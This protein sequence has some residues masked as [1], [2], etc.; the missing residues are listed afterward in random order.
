MSLSDP[1]ADM[2][3]R[4]SNAHGAGLDVVEMPFS[5]LKGEI[6]RLLKREGYVTDFVVEGDVKKTMRI[7]LKYDLDRTPAIRG[8]KR[9]ST[10]GLRSYVGAD[11]VPKVLGGLGITI[12]STSSGVVTGKEAREK[13]IGGEVMCSVW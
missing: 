2:V 5:R 12:L 6:T 3:V 9:V 7:Y 8:I 1:I 11:A 13:N 10:P 4:I